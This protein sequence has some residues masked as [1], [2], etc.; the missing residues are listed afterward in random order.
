MIGC[1]ILVAE[2][3]PQGAIMAKRKKGSKLRKRA[4]LRRGNSAK[5][6]KPRKLAAKRAKPKRASVKRVVRREAGPAVEVR[7]ERAEQQE[8]GP[9]SLA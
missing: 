8:P 6:A 2:H 7:A 5:R 9:A 3:Q 1:L 4:K